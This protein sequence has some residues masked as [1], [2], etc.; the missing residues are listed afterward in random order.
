MTRG[1]KVV[2]NLPGVTEKGSLEE[3]YALELEAL[4]PLG[5]NLVEVTSRD[6]DEFVEAARDAHAVLTRCDNHAGHA[7]TAVEHHGHG[8]V[9]RHAFLHEPGAGARQAGRQAF[10]YLRLRVLS[11]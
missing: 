5:V 1:K 6:A 9:C 11:V 8:N 4:Q 7:D 10:G 2:V 3:R